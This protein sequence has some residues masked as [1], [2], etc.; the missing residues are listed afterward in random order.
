MRSR[1]VVVQHSS[2]AVGSGGPAGALDRVMNSELV[3]RYEFVP[4]LQADGNGFINFK[5]LR[6]WVRLLRDVK[7]DLVHV[8]GLQNEG[9]QAVAAARVAGCKRILV[10]VHGT[11]R[12]LTAGRTSVRRQI[13]VRVA[14]PTTLRAAHGVVTVC[15]YAARRDFVQ[16][17]SK[18]FLGVV[19]NGVDIPDRIDSAARTL[20]RS[21]LGLSSDSLVMT[22]VARLTWEKGFA[23]LKAALKALPSGD[24]SHTP[25]ILIVG[26]GPDRNA[27]EAHFRDCTDTRVIFLGR[28][29]DVSNILSVS[30]I[31]LFPT[32][33]EN[34][35]NAL[36]E[37]MSHGI[38]VIATAVGG[39]VEV[40]ESGGGILVDP[41]DASSLASAI[42]KLLEDPDLRRRLGEDARKTVESRFSTRH[43]VEALDSVYRRAISG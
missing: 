17:N 5:M 38:P 15:D 31:F 30:D 33:H 7:P 37:A 12:D 2:G 40:L 32:L 6:S 1:P 27:I 16:R 11:V 20:I 25:V 35:S 29:S 4:M 21:S 14:E 22:T 24:R 9:F 42:E 39:N 18:N 34:L 8:R 19:H 41:G 23:P 43:M 10:S 3:E 13:L 28:R 26:D 36:L